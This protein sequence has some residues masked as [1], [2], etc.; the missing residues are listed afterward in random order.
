MKATGLG[1]EA[2]EQLGVKTFGSLREE[3]NEARVRPGPRFSWASDWSVTTPSASRMRAR[4][5]S[6]K[7]GSGWGPRVWGCFVAAFVFFLYP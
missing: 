2:G 3:L 5:I 6:M 1:T 7:P 4:L